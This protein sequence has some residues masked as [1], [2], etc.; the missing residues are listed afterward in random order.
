M[1]EIQVLEAA[2]NGRGS[3]FDFLTLIMFEPGGQ[4][5]V[6]DLKGKF[7]KSATRELGKYSLRTEVTLAIFN[8]AICVITEE[9]KGLHSHH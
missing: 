4:A 5:S 8:N 3:K 9:I 7:T 2:L 1:Q 6:I